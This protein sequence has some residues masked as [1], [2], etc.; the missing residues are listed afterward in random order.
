ME[1]IKVCRLFVSL[2]SLNIML[3]MNFMAYKLCKWSCLLSS[4]RF[5]S[6][7]MLESWMCTHFVL[8]HPNRHK[9]VSF[10]RTRR[11]NKSS[12]KIYPEF[13]LKC[14][15]ATQFLWKLQ[16]KFRNLLFPSL[17]LKNL[18]YIFCNR[19]MWVYL[20]FG[21]EKSWYFDNFDLLFPSK[22]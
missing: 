20:L 16:Y 19:D 4:W 10:N 15:V 12:G 2:M 1:S 13:F 11:E 9:Y 7:K 6:M 5:I 22:L 21:F 17:S 14:I 8:L 3:I 18:G